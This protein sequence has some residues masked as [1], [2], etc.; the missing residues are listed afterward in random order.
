[1]IGKR[2]NLSAIHASFS[3]E[4]LNNRRNEGRVEDGI[5]VYECGAN[6]QTSPYLWC[7]MVFA[8]PGYGRLILEQ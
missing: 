7:W 4:L 8:T 1:M 5:C 3:E 2:F 6:E